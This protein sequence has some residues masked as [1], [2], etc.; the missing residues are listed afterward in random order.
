MKKKKKK[1]REKETESSARTQSADKGKIERVGQ[2]PKYTKTLII[3]PATNKSKGG[4]EKPERKTFAKA[5]RN[6][7]REK[8]VSRSFFFRMQQRDALT[9]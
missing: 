2:R 7:R 4:I 1:R 9:G 5:E 3:I 8:K 6:V